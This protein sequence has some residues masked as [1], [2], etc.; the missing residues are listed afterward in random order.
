VNIVMVSHY[1]PRAEGDL[2]GAFIWRLAE[3]LADRGHGVSV[4][5]P[6]D[7]GD[8]GEPMLGK[9]RV[10][11]VR[12]GMPV[13]ETLAYR[14]ALRRRAA[15]PLGIIALAR[16]VRAMGQ[17]V[18]E[19]V[20]ASTAHVI[21][22][23]WWTP[24]GL[25]VRLANRAGRPYVVTLQGKGAVVG[26]RVW[27]GQLA[28]GYVLRPAAAVTAV[29]SNLA[30]IAS[31]VLGVPAASIPITPMPIALGRSPDPDAARHG[32]IYV[33]RLAKEKGVHL[34]LD[35]LAILKR[36]GSATDLTIVGDGPE[37]AA[38]KA[39]AIALGVTVSFLGFVAPELVPGHLRDKRV[40]VHAGLDEGT[41]LVLAEALTQGVPIVA[42][43]AGG[44]PDFLT[45][46]DAGILVPKNDAMALAVA[47]RSVTMDDRFRVGAW[48]ASRALSERLS[49]ER[50]AQTFEAIYLGIRGRRSSQDKRQSGQQPAR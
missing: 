24:S 12:Y 3:A 27:L 45:D 15:T 20:R 36:A 33:G 22:A 14:G 23:H 46:P 28:M 13:Q 48:R 19:E 16:L 47:I 44:A 1:F 9:V 34:L 35:A 38:L 37:R 49:P 31:K 50:V 2:Y 17:A 40:L 43:R 11:R 42:T 8:V 32:A 39:Q 29:S 26:R 21:H 18:T 5:A 41:G 25:A 4:V 30:R 6:A 10:R 7:H